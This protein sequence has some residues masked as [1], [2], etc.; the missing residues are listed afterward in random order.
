MDANRKTAYYALMDVESKKSYSNIALN[1]QIIC[2]KPS[3]PS[4]VRELVYGVL[5]NK[6]LLDYIIDH[7]VQSG[8]A[9]VKLSDLIILR[10]GIYQ[11][12]YMDSVPEYA[13]VNESVILAK[14]FARGRE[15]FIN[16]VLRSYIRNKFSVKLPDRTEDE[17][18]YLSIKYSC[19]PWIVEMWI[20]QYGNET[21]EALLK[22]SQGNPGLS[23]RVNTLKTGKEDLV[24][25]LTERDYEVKDSEIS[26]CG[27]KVIKGT[28]LIEDGLY[29]AG[30]F[31]IQD[32]SSMKTIEILDPQPGETIIDVCAAPGGKTLA[33]AEKMSNRGNIIAR[34]IYLRKLGIINKEAERLGISIVTTSSWDATKMDSELLEKADRVIADVPCSGLG[35]IR[36]KPEIKYKK[37]VNEFEALPRKQLEILTVASKYVKRGG[38][39]QYSTCTINKHENE[40]VIKEFLR[41]N[42]SFSIQEERQFMPHIDETDGFY[43]CKMVK[44]DSLI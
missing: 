32:E 41:K 18:K 40:K 22:S 30:L 16:G 13:A 38:V 35:I 15:S 27:L 5:E 1:H 23:I 21:T 37:R 34:D 3:S 19:E 2:G 28:G 14:K 33:A 39:L 17:I 7:F 10:M 20:K 43:V 31:S 12:G 9:K 11:L 42:K 24:R 8:V 4:F 25:R 29:K 26:S 6:M 44:S 36:K